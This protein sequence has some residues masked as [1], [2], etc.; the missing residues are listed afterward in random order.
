MHIF[1]NIIHEYVDPLIGSL[2]NTDLIVWIILAI[3]TIP[4]TL[5]PTVIRPVGDSESVELT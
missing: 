5:T 4:I 2:R 1:F 3:T